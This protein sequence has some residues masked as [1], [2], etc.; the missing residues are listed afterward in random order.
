M[1]ETGKYV[2]G[3]L[4][5]LLLAFS[6]TGLILWWRT[7]R[8]FEFR[9]WPARMKKGAVIRQHRDTGAVASPLLILTSLTGSFMVFPAFSDAL[10]SPWA[11]SAEVAPAKPKGTGQIGPA[12]D[13]RAVMV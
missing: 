13:W 10:L 2:T 8:S 6:I 5:L 7:R 12:T 4:S 3:I 9:L 1:D 11:Q